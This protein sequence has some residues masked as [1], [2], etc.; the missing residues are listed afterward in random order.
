MALGFDSTR[1][2][3]KGGGYLQLKELP[4]GDFEKVGFIKD[5]KLT[6]ETEMESDFDERGKK[7]AS[8]EGNSDARLTTTLMQASK[9]EIDFVRDSKGKIYSLRY[10]AKREDGNW[11]LFEATL[12]KIR[13]RLELNFDNTPRYIP[14][15]IE[16]LHDEDEGTNWADAEV[17]I[18]SKATIDDLEEGDWPLTT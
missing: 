17:D 12:V 15:E 1:A 13:P 14:L 2:F 5:T 16:L 3:K 18:T 7:V 10:A 11:H 9:E 4:S 6:D 8:H